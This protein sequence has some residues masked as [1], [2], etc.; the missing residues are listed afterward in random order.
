MLGGGACPADA[1]RPAAR[2]GFDTTVFCMVA[3]F[4]FADLDLASCD[5]WPDTPRTPAADLERV[6]QTG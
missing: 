2:R 4:G 6:M 5:F 1:A 3:A